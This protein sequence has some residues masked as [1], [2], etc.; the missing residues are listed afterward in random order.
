MKIIVLPLLQLNIWLDMNM[1]IV[2][3]KEIARAM[4]TTDFNICMHI[5]ILVSLIKNIKI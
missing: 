5:E 1:T 2:C 3:E 4:Q